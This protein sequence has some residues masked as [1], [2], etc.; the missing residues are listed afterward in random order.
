MRAAHKQKSPGRK[1]RAFVAKVLRRSVVAAEPVEGPDQ[2]GPQQPG[3]LGRV[4]EKPVGTPV[5]M[6]TRRRGAVVLRI[7]VF[8][9]P[10]Q[11]GD[12]QLVEG[13]SKPLPMNQPL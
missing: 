12:R 13:Y 7:S 11:S 3:V 6:V 8:S 1:S 5:A 2:L 4:E 9:F 10:E